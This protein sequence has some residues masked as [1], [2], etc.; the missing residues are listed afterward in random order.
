MRRLHHRQNQRKKDQMV[1]VRRGD[2]TASSDDQKSDEELTLPYT[3]AGASETIDEIEAITTCGFSK[4]P[5]NKPPID[6]PRDRRS[7]LYPT[8]G[9]ARSVAID[10]LQRRAKLGKGEKDG[11]RNPVRDIAQS[12]SC[13]NAE[14]V[15]GDTSLPKF[16]QDPRRSN[17]EF[18]IAPGDGRAELARYPIH[19][20]EPCLAHIEER[21]RRR[22]RIAG[23]WARFRKLIGRYSIPCI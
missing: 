13:L 7:I 17:I 20:G 8:G 21:C 10:C 12:D 4:R 19:T 16:L 2:A 11:G 15:R 22:L 9:G 6:A 14:G 23:R 1:N 5:L 3:G 18:P